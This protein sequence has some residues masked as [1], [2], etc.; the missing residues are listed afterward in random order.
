MQRRPSAFTLVELLVVIAIIGMLVSLLL[1][2]VQAAREAARRLSCS[3]NLT[4][5]IIAVH[6]YEMAFEVFPA[7]TLDAKGPIVNQP[8][9]Y[10]HN[11]I[12]RI[13]PFIE[14]P[15][16]YKNI[17]FSVGV[18]DPKNKA[19]SRVRLDLLQCPS[20][21]T[22]VYPGSAYAGVHNDVEAPIDVTNKGSFILNRFLRAKDI[23]DGLAHTA[24]LGEYVPDF[25]DAVRG[26]TW[27]S[28]TRA[29]LRNM[30]SPLA[31]AS[32]PFA[33]PS[34]PADNDIPPAQRA[35]FVGGF[36]SDHPSGVQLAY[37]DGH[38]E[39]ASKNIGLKVLQQVANREDG[40]LIVEVE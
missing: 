25:T 29:T 21:R 10:H 40:Q 35:L 1:P 13:L 14:E 9:G 2:A 11:W 23:S 16:V 4:N 33:T 28:G 38:I 27:M 31:G 37:G 20:L 24:F 39:F 5:L 6:S 22:D 36:G 18:Y 12:S 7:G 3:N 26:L 34:A 17:D 8:V 19:S 15:S 30:G 32:M